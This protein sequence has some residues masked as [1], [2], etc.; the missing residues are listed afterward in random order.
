MIIILLFVFFPVSYSFAEHNKGFL[1]TAPST[2]LSGSVENVCVSLH[3][4]SSPA[5]VSLSLIGTF[6]GQILSK[7]SWTIN[8]VGCIELVVPVTTEQQGRLV[9]HLQSADP[10]LTSNSEVTVQLQADPLVVLVSTDKPLYKPGQQVNFRVVTLNHKLKPFNGKISKI[11]IESPSGVRVEQ[12]S[13]V[14]VIQHGL[15]QLQFTLDKEPFLGKWKIKVH[16]SLSF[17][18][19]KTFVV[20]EYTPAI[21]QVDIKPPKEI[22]PDSP[23]VSWDICAKYSYGEV[24]KGNVR[25]EIKLLGSRAADQP[26]INH[27]VKL[28]SYTGCV[29]VTMTGGELGLADLLVRPTAVQLT[30]IVTE[31]GTA[32]SHSATTQ[33]PVYDQPFRL[34]FQCSQYFKPGLPYKGNVMMKSMDSSARHAVGEN[35]QVCVKVRYHN[36]VMRLLHCWNY[37]TDFSS[38]VVF[39]LPDIDEPYN[40]QIISLVA[41]AMDYPTKLYPGSAEVMVLQPSVTLNVKPWFS[42]SS[43][44]LDVWTRTTLACGT[45]H[46]ISVYYSVTSYNQTTPQ[47]FYLLESR[48]DLVM[49]D[50][51]VPVKE[52]V[53]H[54]NDVIAPH[55]SLVRAWR[56]PLNVSWAMAPTSRL[57]VYYV[58]GNGEVVAGSTNLVID[59]CFQNKVRVRWNEPQLRP[60]QLA[61]LHIR[62]SPYSVCAVTVTDRQLSNNTETTDVWQELKRFSLPKTARDN[63]KYCIN[64]VPKEEELPPTY[65]LRKKRSMFAPPR[66]FGE[67]VDAITA[68]D[69]LGV[70]V[71]S[72]LVLETRPCTKTVFPDEYFRS[73]WMYNLIP[74]PIVANN[75]IL[76]TQP[77]SVSGLREDSE[78]PLIRDHFPDTWIWSLAYT[79]IDGEV[80]VNSSVPDSITSWDTTVSCVSEIH[81]L[82]MSLPTSVSV[83][84][85]FFVHIEAPYSIRMNEKVMIKIVVYNYMQHSLPVLLTVLKNDHLVVKPDCDTPVTLCLSPVSPLSTLISVIP[86]VAGNVNMLVEAQ[87]QNF[88]GCDSPDLPAKSD[89]VVK[90]LTIKHEGYQEQKTYSAFICPSENKESLVSWNFTLPPEDNLV[91]GSATF[92]FSVVADLLGPA[93]ENLDGLL[94]LPMGCGEQNLARLAP[95]LYALKYMKAIGSNNEALVASAVKN[96]KKG[97]QRQLIFRRTDGSFSAFGDKDETGSLWLTAAVVK[98]LSEAQDV[99]EVD[100]GVLQDAVSW[101]TQ[102]QLENGCFLPVGQ[103]FHAE[104]QDEGPDDST[105]ILSALVLANLA[106]SAVRLAPAVRNNAEFCLKSA[107]TSSNPQLLALTVLALSRFGFNQLATETLQNLKRLVVSEIDLVHWGQPALALIAPKTSAKDLPPEGL[108]RIASVLG[109]FGAETEPGPV[110]A[111]PVGCAFTATFFIEATSARLDCLFSFREQRFSHAAPSV[112][113]TEPF[114]ELPRRGV[115]GS[116]GCWFFTLAAAMSEKDLG[117][118]DNMSV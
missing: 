31:I 69:D 116:C 7:T 110:W 111:T 8:S 18:V 117:A 96:V 93:L 113:T 39:A 88:Q 103:L 42:P 25:V 41:T 22:L 58:R 101:I 29:L 50:S 65:D 51:I 49:V 20:K 95:N 19:E 118:A 82:G 99:V 115:V 106:G 97:Y 78:Q 54:Q 90:Q 30:A 34:L 38:Q 102:Q 72:N 71:V 23:V 60:R 9:V 56:L 1:L 33:S 75:M 85:P 16:H 3:N 86:R 47:F 40:V 84:L 100:Q 79:G 10:D 26:N 87:V 52:T 28:N 44:Y 36:Q 43:S 24:L 57:T 4:T 104:I 15:V 74:R 6:S 91:P 11:W 94:R 67:H 59:R 89:T 66:D 107:S 73:N 68:F 61:Q 13:Q 98:T 63:K 112:S 35:I 76:V 70:A 81:G 45:T 32:V 105:T 64:K 53:V 5:Q 27:A 108:T 14:E 80:V 37:T 21:F 114:R 62:A 92:Q 12:W 77:E 109:F 48:G 17:T 46:S 83:F 55:A 2:F